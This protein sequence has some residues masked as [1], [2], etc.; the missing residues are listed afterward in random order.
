M[1]FNNHT[2]QGVLQA[3]FS[4]L[5]A[6]VAA[7]SSNA[8][9]PN[10]ILW[11]NTGTG[12][13]NVGS[14][15]PA[16]NAVPQAMTFNEHAVINNGGT[17]FI[18]GSV[19]NPGAIQLGA[20]DA[21]GG[22]L[23]IRDGGSVTVENN[24]VTSGD[25][26]VGDGAQDGVLSIDRGGS[27]TAQ[28]FST[29]NTGGTSVTLGGGAGTGVATLNAS[30]ITLRSDFRVVGSNASINTSNLLMGGASNLIAEITG[31]SH[32]AIDVSGFARASGTLTLDFNGVT[33]NVGDSWTVIDAQAVAGGFNQVT[34]TASLGPGLAFV[35]RNAAG[36]NGQQVN[37]TLERVLTLKVNRT[38]GAT[39]LVSDSG[40][41]VGLTGYDVTSASGL[42]STGWNSLADQS[43]GSF[44]EASPTANNLSELD[45]SGT[46]NVTMTG[47][48]LG[49]AYAPA[50]APFGSPIPDDLNFSYRDDS[51]QLTTGLVEYEGDGVENT[52]VLTI[53]P[54][55]G[56]ARIKN[57]SLTDIDLDVYTI[58]SA[59]GDLLT[60]WNSLQDQNSGNWQEANPSANRLSELEPTGVLDF[61]AGA[62]FSLDGLWDIA[63][64]QDASDLSLT[65]RDPTLGTF[66]GIVQFGTLAAG[67]IGD[68]NDNGVVDAAD[69]TVW[70]DALGT[71]ATLPNDATPGIV[72][73]T[74]YTLWKLN[75]GMSAG[76]GSAAA[77]VPEPA[78]WLLILPMLGVIL[79]LTQRT[80]QLAPAS[81]LQDSPRSPYSTS[82]QQAKRVIPMGMRVMVAGLAAF[83]VGAVAS[84]QPVTIT[85]ADTMGLAAPFTDGSITI[86]PFDVNGAPASFGPNATFIGPLGGT[87]DNA[88]D[89]ADGDPT[90]TDD[91]ERL[92]IT[93][94]SGFGLTE[95]EFGF[96][97]ANPILFTGFGSDPLASLA[98]NPGGQNAL[99]FDSSTGTLAIFHPFF[100][101]TRTTIQF[102]NSAATD[103]QTISAT[104]TDFNQAGPQLAFT[105][106]TYDTSATLLPGDVDGLNGVTIADYNLIRDNFRSGTTR[107]QG[108]LTGDGLVSL[109][110]FDQWEENFP[111]SSTGLAALL[112]V[113][114]PAS[115]LLV[116]MGALAFTRRRR[117]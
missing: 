43:V 108:D 39:N 71:G 35:Q 82:K 110:D 38:T 73:A 75:F 31:A 74:D 25:V 89:D 54:T 10:D 78:A 107:A 115:I 17:A 33:P 70:R 21:M 90:T 30:A 16:F 69:Y 79:V 76:A 55:T 11:G 64:T 66:T 101:G 41:A 40:T 111:G 72:D 37:A 15:W 98:T 36:G 67:V 2:K 96:S 22:T 81:A 103:G 14:N 93:L 44:Q 26:L 48:N 102:A 100:G 20:T 28:L 34:T 27:L 91:R 58:T 109:A 1:I 61:A 112:A 68:Y 8:Q 47:F 95:L 6:L 92:D 59:A 60:T 85:G 114:E 32:S 19:P 84:A 4:L 56:N 52:L 50:N 77:A 97:R 12:D 3:G 106:F 80:H 94:A 46:T 29:F 86:S 51:G 42:L 99:A 113:P 83:L 23:E 18:A 5:I 24:G 87:N 105:E 45:P 104:V 53:D 62:Q 9:E 88:V 116:A 65:F 63:G 117:L 49:T 57:D 7:T 13:W